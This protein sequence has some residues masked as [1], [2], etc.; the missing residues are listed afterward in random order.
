[1]AGQA[2]GARRLRHQ[3]RRQALD[4]SAGADPPNGAA[5]EIRRTIKRWRLHLRSGSTLADLAR[6]INPI[7]RGWINYYGGFYPTE[8]LRSLRLIN[9]YLVRWAMRKYK[10]LRRRH[11]RARSLLA[12]IATREPALFAHWQAGRAASGWM[13]G[14]R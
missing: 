13:M 9:E 1:M 10:R 2:A 6:S 3:R 11:R 7:V 14:A 8:L 5:K 12:S 4:P